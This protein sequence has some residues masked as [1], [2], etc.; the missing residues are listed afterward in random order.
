MPGADKRSYVAS[1]AGVI[2]CHLIFAKS[3]RKVASA[4]NRGG[5]FDA[6]RQRS[7]EFVG[8]ADDQPDCILERGMVTPTKLNALSLLL[9]DH[10]LLE[11]LSCP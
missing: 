4:I 11:S 9:G 7:V 2:S 5:M 6:A 3:K 1:R 10:A 8:L